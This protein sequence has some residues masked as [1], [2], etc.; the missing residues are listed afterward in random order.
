MSTS[1][2]V[3]G[4]AREETI[5][6][7]TSCFGGRGLL[8]KMS[9]SLWLGGW[10]VA[11][12]GVSSQSVE[13]HGASK[14]KGTEKNVCKMAKGLTLDHDSMAGGGSLIEA[15]QNFRSGSGMEGADTALGDVRALLP[16][17]KMRRRKKTRM[18][19]RTRKRIKIRPATEAKQNR[20]RWFDRDR[21]VSKAKNQLEAAHEKLSCC[22]EL[23]KME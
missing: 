20:L 18:R 13:C 23:N 12:G 4:K 9:I 1:L 16:H 17:S 3:V 22:A 2:R 14:R 10:V 21:A 7:C 11:V 15:A 6:L 8:G 19:K 5:P